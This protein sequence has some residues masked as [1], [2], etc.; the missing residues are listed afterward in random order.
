MSHCFSPPIHNDVISEHIICYAN[1]TRS[2]HETSIK[3]KII[4]YDNTRSSSSSSNSNSNSTQHPSRHH[5]IFIHN[6]CVRARVLN[7]I[8]RFPPPFGPTPANGR[9]WL[10]ILQAAR[11]VSDDTDGRVFGR[12]QL[13][14]CARISGPFRQFYRRP[15]QRSRRPEYTVPAVPTSP[16]T[17]NV[18]VSR[19]KSVNVTRIKMW[20]VSIAI[21]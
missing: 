17:P 19:D 7:I 10:S 12:C 20:N 8:I 1:N 2:A 16:D 11:R 4:M 5:P 9:A 15:S 3:I 6:V 14:A 18:P 13:N 21:E